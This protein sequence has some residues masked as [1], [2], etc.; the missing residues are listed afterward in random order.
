MYA[1]V[2]RPLTLLRLV[3]AGVHISQNDVGVTQ[4]LE[5]SYHLA[6]LFPDHTDDLLGHGRPLLH[7]NQNLTCKDRTGGVWKKYIWGGD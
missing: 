2:L 7:Q 1:T 5:P 4:A 6:S 3:L